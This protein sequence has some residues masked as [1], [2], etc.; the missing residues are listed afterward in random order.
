VRQWLLENTSKYILMLDDDQTFFKWKSPTD[1]HLERCSNDEVSE[2]FNDIQAY[3][4]TGEI[5]VGIA[6]RQG[7]NN[8]FPDS[9]KFNIRNCNSYGV[10]TEY[11]NKNNIVFNAIPVMEDFHVQLSLLTS[12]QRTICITDRVWN[13]VGSGA[14][15]GCSEYRTNELQTEAA[16]KLKDC[17]PDFVKLVTKNNKTGWKGMENRTDVIISW[18]KAYEFG[19]REL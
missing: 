3:L 5:F 9:I 17:F 1:Y 4:E 13:Q 11:L 7:N 16:Q 15:G 6:S 14:D 19:R 2:L 10:N 8:M 12:G 18:K